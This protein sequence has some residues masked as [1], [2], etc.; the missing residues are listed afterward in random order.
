MEEDRNAGNDPMR[1]HVLSFEWAV[2]GAERRLNE[3]DTDDPDAMEVRDRQGMLL[4]HLQGQ[5]QS[6]L[7]QVAHLKSE[8]HQLREATSVAP[9]SPTLKK[10]KGPRNEPAGDPLPTCL[11]PPRPEDRDQDLPVGMV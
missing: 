8:I 10:Q 4:Q 1:D 7:D 5:L 6:A 2:A 9:L 3:R 11:G